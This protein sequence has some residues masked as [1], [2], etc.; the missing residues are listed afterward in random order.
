MRT[1]PIVLRVAIALRIFRVWI[2]HFE[3]ASGWRGGDAT[4]M[5]RVFAVQGLPGWSVQV[6]GAI[7]VLFTA[8]LTVGIRVPGT[9]LRAAGG[10]AAFMPDAVAMHVKAK[11]PGRRQGRATIRGSRPSWNPNWGRPM[12]EFTGAFLLLSSFVRQDTDFGTPRGPSF[13]RDFAPSRPRY[14]ASSQKV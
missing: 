13:K 4:R 6:T 10:L 5:Q 2:L 14:P 8:G 12:E 7:T 1:T 9:T 3:R 11:D